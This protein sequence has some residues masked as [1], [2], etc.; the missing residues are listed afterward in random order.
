MLFT[1]QQP[2]W[3]HY[4]LYLH[5]HFIPEHSLPLSQVCMRAQ[6]DGS[7]RGLNPAQL[8][9]GAIPLCMQDGM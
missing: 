9:P 2:S 8:G 3:Q 6:S 4:Q 7:K 5:P 1:G